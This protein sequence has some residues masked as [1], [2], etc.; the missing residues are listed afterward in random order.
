MKRPGQQHVHPIYQLK[1]LIEKL[2]HLDPFFLKQT[3]LSSNFYVESVLRFF[4]IK[5]RAIGYCPNFR[6]AS[7]TF[8]EYF[9][10]TNVENEHLQLELSENQAQF[11]HDAAALE[12]GVNLVL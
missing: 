10:L 11:L 12:L 1:L 8:E 3:P 4:E 6:P 9:H 2:V 5:R 7:L